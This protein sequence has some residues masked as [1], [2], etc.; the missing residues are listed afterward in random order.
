MSVTTEHCE[1][2]HPGRN[3]ST[4][5]LLWIATSSAFWYTAET[6]VGFRTWRHKLCNFEG[7]SFRA[8]ATDG[9][10]FCLSSSFPH[11][12]PVSGVLRR[13]IS[14]VIPSRGCPIRFA[15]LQAAP[16]LPGLVFF[17]RNSLSSPRPTWGSKS[18]IKKERYK[19]TIRLSPPWKI[20]RSWP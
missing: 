4:D 5:Y 20:W 16:I 8:G 19:G 17:L 12:F 18:E 9:V 6:E 3:C 15:L 10:Y 13:L 11:R 7:S 2:N 1:H 14:S